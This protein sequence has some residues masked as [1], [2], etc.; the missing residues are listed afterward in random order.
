MIE[1]K[2][3]YNTAKVFIDD[4]EEKA[5]SQI[6][7]LLNQ[8]VFEDCKVRIMTDTHAGA[9]CVIGFT[10]DIGERV[11]PNLVGVDIGCG[12][13]VTRFND[14]IDLEELDNFIRHNIPHG[15]SVNKVNS[16][17]LAH[18]LSDDLNAAIRSVSERTNTDYERHLLSLGTL[19][20][21]N[22]FIEVN[23]DCEG[24]KYLVIHS[25]SR[26][27]GLQ[28]AKYHQKIAE[29]NDDNKRKEGINIRNTAVG[30]LRRQKKYQEADKLYKTLTKTIE[31]NKLPKELCYLMFEDR[32]RYLEDMGWAQEFASLNRRIIMNTILREFNI[33]TLDRFETI[34]NYINFDDNI[35]RKGAVSA[36]KGEKIIIPINMR[37]GSIIAE[38]KGN[39]DWNNS[40]PHGAGRLMSRSKAKEVLSVEDFKDQ[41]TDVFTTSVKE[42]T[43]DEAPDAY[44]SMDT[45]LANIKETVSV[46]DI[47]KPIYNFKA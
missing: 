40:A 24:K 25:G 45:I 23:E 46:I 3:K 4:I 42:S 2:G 7:N 17:F 6:I 5:M 47:I 39:D 10:A 33:K 19:G 44:K 32:D 26:N 31:E 34:H 8:K 1:L 18:Y 20:G 15:N 16:P 43:L 27:F 35:I 28:V 12:M 21:G 38:G 41:M 36:N 37:D 13:S 14:N 11:I 29:D 9:G 22:H 30:D